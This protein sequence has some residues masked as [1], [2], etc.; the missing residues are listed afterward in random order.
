[1]PPVVAMFCAA[2]TTVAPGPSSPASNSPWDALH[3][4]LRM[5]VITSGQACLR[6]T[7]HLVSPGYADGLGPGPVYP[8]GPSDD[9]VLTVVPHGDGHLQKVLWVASAACPGPVL[10]RGGRVDGPGTLNLGVSADAA[11]H[12]ELQLGEATATSTGEEPGWR[13]WPSETSTSTLG[14]YAYQVDGLGFTTL[15]VFDVQGAEP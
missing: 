5:P 4:P 9:G 11:T 10:I 12:P 8:G 6:S 7:G 15:V 2:C 13:E 3:T 14:C 1:M